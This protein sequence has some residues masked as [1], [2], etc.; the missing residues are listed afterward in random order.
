[1]AAAV[2]REVGGLLW[3]PTDRPQSGEQ[4][5]EEAREMRLR[6]PALMGCAIL[7][8]AA[9]DP[10]PAGNPD[11]ARARTGVATGAVIGAVLGATRDGKSSNNARDA[12]VGAAAGAIIGGAI[13]SALDAQARELQSQ[14]GPN[15]QIINDGNQLRV[16]MPQD[17]LFAVDS[18]TLQPALVS[19]LRAVASSLQRYP[20][21]TVVVEG[22]TD[23][24]GEAAYNMD[25]SQRRA[26]AVA[27]TL[28]GYGVPAGRVVAVGRGE[29]SPVASNLTPEGRALNRRVEIVIR[30][31]R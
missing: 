24:T 11:N 14:V 23:N 20:D 8:L 31:T 22:H 29:D 6:T 2:G 25:L 27:S 28:T 18:A 13:G 26:S 16:V 15:V 30:P 9:C 21:S 3:L 1:M 7:A 4:P 12:L 5:S 17:I 10:N 19:D